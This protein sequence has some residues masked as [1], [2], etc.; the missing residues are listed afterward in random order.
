[1]PAPHSPEFRKRS[2][3]LDT[4]DVLGTVEDGVGRIV[5]N[6]PERRNALSG[7]MLEGLATLLDEFEKADDV[8]AVVL[9]GA[10]SAFCAGGDVKAFNERGGEGGGAAEVSQQR[11]ERQRVMQRRTTARIHAF[12]KPVLGV[13]PGAAAGAGL[14]LALACDLRIGSTRAVIAT[15][16]GRVGLSGDYG[17]TWLLNRLVGP[18]RARELMF[19]SPRLDAARALELGLLNWVVAEDELESKADDIARQ[20]ANGP[21]HAL[22]A[23]KDNLLFAGSAQLLASM[24]HEVPLH[25]GCGLTADHVE[26]VAAFVEKREPVF[27]ADRD[28]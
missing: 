25:L 26:A 23:M 22:A 2:I 15:A 17:A 18:A 19:L 9:T 11:V 1:V 5:L 7:L 21:R 28:R 16:F 24:D 10:G 20:L 14:G 27:G 6:R 4:T 12:A 8:G 3:D 13:L